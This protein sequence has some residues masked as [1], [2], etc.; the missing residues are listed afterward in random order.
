MKLT[1]HDLELYLICSTMFSHKLINC[2]CNCLTR[3]IKNNLVNTCLWHL[4]I[5]ILWFGN[6]ENLSVINMVITYKALLEKYTKCT[7]K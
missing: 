3:I 2:H 1:F 6:P 5:E 7:C 4:G